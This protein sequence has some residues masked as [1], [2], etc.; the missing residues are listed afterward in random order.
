MCSREK[1]VASLL[2]HRGENPGDATAVEGEKKKP[3]VLDAAASN[4]KKLGHG[5]A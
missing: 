3:G 4:L 2:V 5:R 1:V